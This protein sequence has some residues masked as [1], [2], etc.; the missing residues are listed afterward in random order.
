MPQVP[1]VARRRR[2]DGPQ[3]GRRCPDPAAAHVGAFPG[4]DR[5]TGMGD[6]AAAHQ[7]MGGSHDVAQEVDA[8]LEAA[9]A[10]VRFER[11][12]QLTLQEGF[13]LGLPG[14]E[15]GAVLVDQH[16]V[17]DV[18]QVALRLQGVLHELVESVQVDVGQELAAEVPDRKPAVG[19]GIG[20]ALVRRHQGQFLGRRSHTDTGVER[21]VPQ[22]RMGGMQLRR[23]QAS[24]Q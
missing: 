17:V 3:I 6:D 7:R 22:Q 19:P 2:L 24:A 9:Q 4:G 23:R 8:V 14:L 21:R 20:Q 11:Q 18:A 1:A 16:E 5:G 12:P 13:D 10:D 15:L